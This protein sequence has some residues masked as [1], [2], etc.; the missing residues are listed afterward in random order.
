MNKPVTSSDITLLN[1]LV[2]CANITTDEVFKDFKIMANKKI[3][4]KHI[5]EIYYSESEKSWRTYL[6][7]NTKPNNR[8]PIKR[9]SKEN[10]EKEIIRF[11]IEKQEAEN[12]ESITLEDLYSEWLLY[13]RDYTS[14]KAKTIQEYVAEWNKFF[15]DTNLAK[16]KIGEIKP[17]TLIRFFREITKKREYTHKR[18]SNARSVLN[19]IMSYAIEEEI[20]SHNH[21]SDVNFKQFTYK[22]VEVQSD[23]VFSHDDTFKLLNYL[24]CII[25]PYSLAIQLSF[26][27]FIR[28]GETKAIRWEDIDYKNRVVYLHRQATCER[29]L[30]DDLTFSKREV[31][32]VNQMKGNTSHGYRKQ[33]LTDE[34][35]TILEKAKELNPCGT[36]LFEPD[37]AIM[38]T[39]SFNRRLKKYCKEAGVPY[40]SSHKIRFYNASTAFDGNNLTTL[41]YLMG[42]SEVATTLHYLRNVNKGE[43]N[44]LAFQKLGI[45]S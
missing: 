43:N 6:P 40:H 8:R 30:N 9:K 21:V 28:V 39:D 38:T 41:S 37:G 2:T 12:R 44:M 14:V 7:D 5:Y 23:N 35:I 19:G 25:E 27:L 33:Y 4:E 16:M 22:P 31:K 32:V 10:L 15:K 20:I 29:V 18:I 42:H 24:K 26:Y 17:I 3:L 13:K 1:T 11:Y 34:A 45:S 36:Y